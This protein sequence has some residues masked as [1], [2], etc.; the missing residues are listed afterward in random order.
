MLIHFFCHRKILEEVSVCLQVCAAREIQ[1]SKS[2]PLHQVRKGHAD[3]E[4][5]QRRPGSLLL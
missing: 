1:N 5:S 2:D 3:G 4:L